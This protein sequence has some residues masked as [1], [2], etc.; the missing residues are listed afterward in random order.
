MSLT[1]WNIN[2]QSYDLD[3]SDADVAARYEDTFEQMIAREKALPVDGK[4]SA[5]IRAVYAMHRD[6][7]DGIFGSGAGDAILGGKQNLNHCQQIY[8]QFLEFVEEQQRAHIEFRN[9]L[10]SRYSPARLQRRLQGNKQ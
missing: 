4:V 1:T 6:L 2:D 9:Q 8:L 3:L 5:Y 10:Q 7:Y